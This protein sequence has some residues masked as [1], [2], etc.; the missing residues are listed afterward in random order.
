MSQGMVIKKRMC[1]KQAKRGI[2]GQQRLQIK[3]NNPRGKP[4]EHFNGTRFQTL[5]IN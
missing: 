3:V 4:T 2:L 1:L 5:T